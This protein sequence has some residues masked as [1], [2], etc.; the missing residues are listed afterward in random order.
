MEV[1]PRARRNNKLKWYLAW[2]LVN[3]I[4]CA[5]I[6]VLLFLFWDAK[7]WARDPCVRTLNLWLLVYLFLQG[8]HTLRTIGVMLVWHKAKDPSVQQLKIELFFGV[9][10]FIA[11]ASWIIYGN[12]FIYSDEIENCQYQPNWSILTTETERNTI[13]VLVIY[14]YFLLA[15]I[16]FTVCFFIAFFFGYKQYIKADLETIQA[17]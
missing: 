11:E 6:S 4:L 16:L 7:Q 10:V 13:M 2:L 14:G 9:W 12:T 3:T 8:L 5:Y 15:G 17:N 1:F